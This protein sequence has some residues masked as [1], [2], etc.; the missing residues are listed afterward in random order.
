MKPHISHQDIGYIV[1]GCLYVLEGPAPRTG[2]Q[3]SFT[4]PSNLA[5]EILSVRS[6]LSTS[7][8]GADRICTLNA[9]AL[10][11]RYWDSPS[12]IGVPT[13]SELNLTWAESLSNISDGTTS[14]A[15]P[16]GRMILPPSTTLEI[17]SFQLQPTDAFGPTVVIAIAYS[18]K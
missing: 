12:A 1:G 14:I 16:L 6:S 4:T 10:G 17:S 9:F 5:L 7:G 13:G 15:I 8:V 2:I 18:L 11:R 3:V